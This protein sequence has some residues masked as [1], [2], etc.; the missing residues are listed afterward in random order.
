[1]NIDH[2]LEALRKSAIFRYGGFEFE[3]DV[4]DSW[5]HETD[6]E[7]EECRKPRKQAPTTQQPFKKGR[8]GFSE[9]STHGALIL[10]KAFCGL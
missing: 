8:V 2:A 6:E 7:E 10:E 9:S 4:G 1:M 3:A 5:L